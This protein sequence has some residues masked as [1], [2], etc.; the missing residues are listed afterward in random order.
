[1]PD[2]AKE[3]R[4]ISKLWND[5]EPRSFGSGIPDERYTAELVSMEVGHSKKGRLQVASKF[6][7]KA[8]KYKGSEVTRFDGI[9]NENNI[10]FF[11]GY[12]EVIGLDVPSD[13]EELLNACE[14][15]VDKNDDTFDI[16]LVTNEGGF[17]NI[18]VSGVASGTETE[19]TDEGRDNGKRRDRTTGKSR[20]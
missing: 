15:F 17:Q 9:E 4:K 8:G 7:I 20:R 11:K 2:V 1:M 13:P 10:A 6:R 12:C 19:T 16:A 3:L 14:D 5:T 18:Q